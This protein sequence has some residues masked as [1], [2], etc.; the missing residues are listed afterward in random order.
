M[1]F[2]IGCLFILLIPFSSL[3]D[4][5]TIENSWDESWEI[6][7]S[8]WVESDSF[9]RGIFYNEESPYYGIKT[10]CTDALI[11][12][13]A[14]FSYENKLPFSVKLNKQG[15]RIAQDTDRFN[16]SE[17]PLKALI[18]YIGQE[19]GTDGFARLNTYPVAFK[20]LRPGDFYLSKWKR[21]EKWLFHGEI[22]KKI[23]E[24][25]HLMTF[26]STSPV[27]KRR[28]AQREGYPAK[29]FTGKP[30]GFRRFLR[31]DQNFLNLA[32]NDQY[33]VLERDPSRFFSTLGQTLRQRED[34]FNENLYRR[35]GNLCRS[36][37]DRKYEVNA[38][39]NYVK[40]V[41][42][43][44]LNRSE[45]HAY[46][47]PSRDGTLYKDLN[48]LMNGWKRIRKTSVINEIDKRLILFLEYLIRK[49]RSEA[50]KQAHR[51]VCLDFQEGEVLSPKNY[52]LKNFFDG[53]YN[54]KIS[55]HPND[56]FEARWGLSPSKTSC[57]S[58]Y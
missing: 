43:R 58:F 44:C 54:N 18:E 38:A 21:K 2:I 4:V 23:L 42:H 5:W 19:I 1:N 30:F 56:S 36:L 51:E 28:L 12:L 34:T 7:W 47:T 37:E 27:A 40:S 22:I 35:I 10:D 25:G 3:A 24:T 13:R 52:T 8:E 55:S 57:P 20:D 14:I 31:E 41:G 45:Y 49:D 11:A 46:S 29:L 50:A 26:Y 53:K 17:R 15:L 39:I 32:N 33:K 48:R 16:E 6:K 9:Q